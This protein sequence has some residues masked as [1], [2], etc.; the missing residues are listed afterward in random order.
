VRES[1]GTQRGVVLDNKKRL[2]ITGPSRV[3]W[4]EG[5]KELAQ[6]HMARKTAA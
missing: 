2:A 1:P 5:M 4:R 3:S 6:A